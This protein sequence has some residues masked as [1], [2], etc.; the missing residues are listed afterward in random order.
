MKEIDQKLKQWIPVNTIIR[1]EV[2]KVIVDYVEKE[3]NKAYE[4]GL[5]A[6]LDY[7]L[8]TNTNG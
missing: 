8:N 1:A 3:V 5:E 2:R 6:G 4:R 7:K